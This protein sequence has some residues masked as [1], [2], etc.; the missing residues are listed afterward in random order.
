MFALTTAGLLLRA[1]VLP[2]GPTPR[3]VALLAAVAAAAALTRATGLMVAAVAVAAVLA[4]V[5]LNDRRPARRRVVHAVAAAGAV[6]VTVAAAAGWFYLRNQ[7]LYGSATGTDALLQ[8]F[9]R[10]ARG[11]VSQDLIDRSYWREHLRRLWEY[12]GGP[13]AHDLVSKSWLLTFLPVLGLAFAAVRWLRKAE[14]PRPPLL[15]AWLACLAVAVLVEFS[16]I[17]FYSL[18]GQP[19]GRYLLPVLGVLAVAAAAGM[20]GLPGPRALPTIAMLP[21]LVVVNLIAWQRY[22]TVTL[23]PHG[24]PNAILTGLRSGHLPAWLL[25]PAGVLLAAGLAGQAWALWTLSARPAL[26]VPMPAPAH[27]ERQLTYAGSGAAPRAAS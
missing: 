25:V 12:T 26:P 13:W 16:A 8:K 11:T 7:A 18:G 3:R 2:R 22:L 15:L 9:S 14:P 24:G 23:L 20:A 5:L 21:V 27:P 17:S 10:T 6:A 4:A 19:H 1:R